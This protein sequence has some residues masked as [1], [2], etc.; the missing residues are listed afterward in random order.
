MQWAGRT[1]EKQS[2]G[3]RGCS[4]PSR[5]QRVQVRGGRSSPPSSTSGARGHWQ[6]QGQGHRLGIG[7]GRGQGTGKGRGRGRGPGTG[8][9]RR[10]GAG[11]KAEALALGLALLLRTFDVGEPSHPRI[12]IV[13]PASPCT[14]TLGFLPVRFPGAVLAELGWGTTQCTERAHAPSLR[15]VEA[16]LR[17]HDDV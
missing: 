10:R 8:R 7:R 15:S 16:D 13:T 17:L 12:Y 11:A 9:G 6:G 1:P 3:G 5:L 14:R 4:P 2:V